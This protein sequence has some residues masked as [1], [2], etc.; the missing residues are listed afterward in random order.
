MFRHPTS[1][2]YFWLLTKMNYYF[3][4]HSFVLVAHKTVCSWL[5]TK[6]PHTDPQTV[7]HNLFMPAVLFRQHT[8]YSSQRSCRTNKALSQNSTKYSK[9]IQLLK[10][11]PFIWNGK[12]RSHSE[13]HSINPILITFGQ[14][15]ILIFL[16]SILILYI[17]LFHGLLK[18]S[19]FII[20]PT[21]ILCEPLSIF[22]MHTT[23][24]SVLDISP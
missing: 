16:W 18:L 11:Y 15:Y 20:F 3:L 21:N 1:E 7:L 12:G 23:L 4:N 9:V 6:W 22:F 2:C 5:V 13:G 14:V 17:L 8:L 19:L 24:R 10:K